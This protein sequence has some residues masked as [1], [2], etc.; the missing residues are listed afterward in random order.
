MTEAQ[1]LVKRGGTLL[2]YLSRTPRARGFGGVAADALQEAL[3]RVAADARWLGS[4]GSEKS[5]RPSIPLPFKAFQE[6]FSR[7]GLRC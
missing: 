5:A 1:G 6:P 2:N 4:L 3:I 7:L